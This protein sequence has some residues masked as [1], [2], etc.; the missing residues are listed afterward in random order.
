[1]T[2]HNGRRKIKKNPSCRGSKANVI[3]NFEDPFKAKGMQDQRRL[4]SQATRGEG[5]NSG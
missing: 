2:P 4:K 5:K 3:E 1:M